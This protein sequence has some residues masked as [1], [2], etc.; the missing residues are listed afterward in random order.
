MSEPPYGSLYQDIWEPVPGHYQITYRALQ[1]AVSVGGV[2][3]HAVSSLRNLGVIMDST[4]DMHSQ[5]QSVKCA[6]FHHLRTISNIRR[7]LHRD[8]CVKAV[9]SLVMSRVDYCNSLLVGQSAAALRGLQLAQNYAA[10]L[11]MGVRRRDHVTPTLQALHWLPIHQRVCYRL[12]C[13]LHKTLYTVT[14]QST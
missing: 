14:H 11:V 9:L 8:T 7:F 2:R 12:M 5:I 1:P 13:L 10:R 3:V 4:M 6:M